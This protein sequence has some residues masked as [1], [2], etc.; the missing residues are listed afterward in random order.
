M[1]K[2][3]I[4]VFSNVIYN[5]SIERFKDAKFK[6]MVMIVKLYNFFVW[7]KFNPFLCHKSIFLLYL[8]YVKQMPCHTLIYKI[9]YSCNLSLMAC[10]RD[11]VVHTGELPFMDSGIGILCS[12]QPYRNTG[13]IWGNCT[14]LYQQSHTFSFINLCSVH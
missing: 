1:E 2:L 8:S 6:F 3:K 7:P 12:V 14:A 9:L 11:L 13:F 4:I 5:L 10:V